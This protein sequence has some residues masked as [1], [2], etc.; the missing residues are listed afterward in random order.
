MTTG[1]GN[2][3]NPHFKSPKSSWPIVF[4]QPHFNCKILP[5]VVVV[6]VFE[7][8]LLLDVW[9]QSWQQSRG[10]SQVQLLLQDNSSRHQCCSPRSGLIVNTDCLWN[11]ISIC[12]EPTQKET[13]QFLQK[14]I[15]FLKKCVQYVISSS[16]ILLWLV[17]LS[18]YLHKHNS[19]AQERWCLYLQFLLTDTMNEET[20]CSSLIGCHHHTL[21]SD[22][23][24]P[25]H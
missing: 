10:G 17:S 14:R 9:L 16:L 22:W 4:P 15:S 11:A 19:R 25:G 3:L 13:I 12:Q 20:Q 6:V 18:N 7:V 21:S 23:L 1:C 2:P 24:T 8:D 5:H